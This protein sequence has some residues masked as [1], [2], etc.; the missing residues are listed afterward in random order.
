VSL[1]LNVK[2]CISRDLACG[3]R[4]IFGANND[5]QVLQAGAIVDVGKHDALLPA[6][7]SDPARGHNFLIRVNRVGMAG[8][9]LSNRDRQLPQRL[10]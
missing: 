10:S 1:S 2:I 6:D 5:L 7:G 4:C 3:P 9:E 8:D